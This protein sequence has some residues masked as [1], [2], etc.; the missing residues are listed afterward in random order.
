MGKVRVNLKT[1]RLVSWDVDGTLYS[2]R[3]MQ[4]FLLRSL[5]SQVVK[6]RARETWRDL[7]ILKGFRT[8][9][10]QARSTD[11]ILNP[12]AEDREQ[13]C[14]IQK[15]WFGTAIRQTGPRPGLRELLAFFEDRQLVQVAFSDY[16]PNYKV[17]ELGLK[18]WFVAAYAG[19]R[20]G[21]VKPS[22]KAFFRISADFSTPLENILHIG[23]R[24]DTDR[25]AAV[26]AGCQCIILGK[27][28]KSFP[29][30]LGG[31]VNQ[32]KTELQ[33]LDG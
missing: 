3:W 10:E 23:D 12:G 14:R 30:L 1:I 24:A 7:E 18:K 4:W 20:L 21:F 6:G 29:E 22:P 9:I 32:T 16:E 2:P 33:L 28:F 11:G 25:L 19:D 17:E 26:A 13:L 31:L 27:D 15:R 8:R 5:I